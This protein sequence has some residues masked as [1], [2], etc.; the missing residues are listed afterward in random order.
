V[1][2]RIETEDRLELLLEITTELACFEGHFPGRPILPGI[3]Q[4]DWAVQFGT[5]LGFDPDKFTAMPRLKF[6][7][8]IEPDCRVTLTLRRTNT[9]LRFTYTSGEIL[10]SQGLINFSGQE[11]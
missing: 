7:T 4:V 10:F 1:L 2:K 6:Q 8:L 11:A 5:A 9:G 3:A